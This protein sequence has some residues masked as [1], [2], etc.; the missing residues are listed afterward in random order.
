MVFAAR[1]HRVRTASQPNVI[2]LWRGAR[3]MNDANSTPYFFYFSSLRRPAS[4]LDFYIFFFFVFVQLPAMKDD[5]A[6][7]GGEGKRARGRFTTFYFVSQFLFHLSGRSPY[8]LYA[9]S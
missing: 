7:D 8:T 5:S 2:F 9:S 6:N 3:K 1:R 4:R